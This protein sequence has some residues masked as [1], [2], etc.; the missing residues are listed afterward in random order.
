LLGKIHGET[1]AR[2]KRAITTQNGHQ[3][4]KSIFQ[5]V[6]KDVKLDAI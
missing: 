6:L 1:I 3:D 5:K 2:I 4:A